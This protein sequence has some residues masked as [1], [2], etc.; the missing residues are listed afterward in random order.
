MSIEYHVVQENIAIFGHIV[1]EQQMGAE[2]DFRGMIVM[3]LPEVKE[4]VWASGGPGTAC[5]HR[6]ARR[7]HPHRHRICGQEH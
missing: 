7:Y 5:Q 6:H 3:I 4:T 1:T 2:V